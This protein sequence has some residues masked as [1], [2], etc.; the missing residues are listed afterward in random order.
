MVVQGIMSCLILFLFHRFTACWILCF[1]LFLFFFL[2]FITSTFLHTA[3]VSSVKV[4]IEP[5]PPTIRT[6]SPA[7]NPPPR[8]RTPSVSIVTPTLS[9]SSPAK[10]PPLLYRSPSPSSSREEEALDHFCPLQKSHSLPSNTVIP[11]TH[12]SA[13]STSLDTYVE[14]PENFDPSPANSVSALIVAPPSADAFF[15]A[16][17]HS[18]PGHRLTNYLKFL[19]EL[20]AKGSSIAHLFSTAVISGSLSAP[21]L[22]KEMPCQGENMGEFSLCNSQRKYL[23]F[24]AKG[25][26]F[27]FLDFKI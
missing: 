21:N 23:S 2:S 19:H 13:L 20:A 25:T 26:F 10:T 18:I 5:P 27:H 7:K 14:I 15:R 12:S 17:R 11:T 9:P 16:H 24:D 1:S 8:I 22:E 4:Y 3:S 6:S